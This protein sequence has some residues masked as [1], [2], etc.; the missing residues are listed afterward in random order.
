[1]VRV[2]MASQSLR[3]VVQLP[4]QAAPCSLAPPMLRIC[5]GCPPVCALPYMVPH[6]PVL[7]GDR[8]IVAHAVLKTTRNRLE[9]AVTQGM[10]EGVV[11]PVSG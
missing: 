2:K 10:A 7:E 8:S 4:V 1:M 3:R 6:F 9:K 5:H 11:T